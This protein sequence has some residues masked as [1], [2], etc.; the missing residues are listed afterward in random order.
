MKIKSKTI[1]KVTLS[2]SITLFL[3]SLMFD[4]FCTA[5]GCMPSILAFVLGVLGLPLIWLSN[6]LLLLSWITIKRRPTVSLMLGISALLV[7]ISFL[8]FDEI[9]DFETGEMK[10][11]IDYKL[12]YWI[13]VLSSLPIIVGN[14]GQL[15]INK[16]KEIKSEAQEGIDSYEE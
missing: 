3:L 14:L 6:P 13:W 4:S 11:I 8:F 7:S 10:D 16:K 1:R 12:G 5:D 2:F 15:N 9:K